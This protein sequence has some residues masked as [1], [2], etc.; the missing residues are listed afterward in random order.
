MAKSVLKEC[1]A[2]KKRQT[3][4]NDRTHCYICGSILNVVQAAPEKKPKMKKRQLRQ[5]RQTDIA[6]GSNARG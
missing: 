4:D 2:C 1:R 6:Y 5:R 3:V